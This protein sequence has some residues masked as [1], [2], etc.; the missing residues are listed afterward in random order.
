MI[1]NI[2]IKAVREDFLQL[3]A[4]AK[5]QEI[6]GCA[7]VTGSDFGNIAMK[8][9]AYTK[10]NRTPN[11][12]VDEWRLASL[13]LQSSALSLVDKEITELL[14]QKQECLKDEMLPLFIDSLKNLKAFLK[15]ENIIDVEKICFFVSVI[16]DDEGIELLTATE[17]NSSDILKSFLSSKQQA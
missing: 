1:K 13:E 7:L 2:L 3:T 10:R 4:S 9:A 15:Q 16:D 5:N 11:W 17:L 14:I 8:I 12:Y 6:Y